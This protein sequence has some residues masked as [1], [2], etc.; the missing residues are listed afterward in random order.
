MATSFSVEDTFLECYSALKTV[1]SRYLGRTDDVEDIVQDTFVHVYQAKAKS[2]I[3]DIRSYLFR[4]ARN[5]SLNQKNLHA[6]RLT[7]HLGELG[8]DGIAT[9]NASPELKFEVHEEFSVFCEAVRA[10]PAQCQRV[11]ILKKVYGLSHDE[12]AKELNI[13]VGTSNQHLAK[14][15]ALCTRYMRDRGYLQ[16]SKEQSRGTT[17]DG[18]TS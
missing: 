4:T 13:K 7:D 14:G 16:D 9:D 10:L 12:I 15:I 3:L 18:T 17:A 6:N 2:Q 11:L 1:V 8:I 5:L